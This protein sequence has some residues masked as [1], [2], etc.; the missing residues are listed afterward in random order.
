MREVRAAHQSWAFQRHRLW[1][2]EQVATSGLRTQVATPVV[3]A[4]WNA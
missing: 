1:S 4:A 3:S 2:S